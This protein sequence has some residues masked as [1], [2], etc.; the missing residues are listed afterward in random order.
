MN[1]TCRRWPRSPAAHDGLGARSELVLHGDLGGVLP[2]RLR[3]RD[4]GPPQPIV[5]D[6]KTVEETP[7]GR[8][9]VFETDYVTVV[10]PLQVGLKHGLRRASG[11]TVGSLF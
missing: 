4:L 11:V 6:G 10:V 5:L 1:T 2:G 9:K 3:V 7:S 8:K